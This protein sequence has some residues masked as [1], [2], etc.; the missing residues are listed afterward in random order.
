LD[1][2]PLRESIGH[3][4]SAS[5]EL[6]QEKQDA[7][8][9]F[10]KLLSKL[11]HRRPHNCARG[12]FKKVADWIKGV[13]GVAPAHPTRFGY[14]SDLKQHGSTDPQVTRDVSNTA[15]D[16]SRYDHY[17]RGSLAEGLPDDYSKLIK[18]A[19]RVR[20]ANKKLT[21]FER[22]FIDEQGIKDRSW[23]RHLGVAPGKWL[24]K[25]LF[26]AVGPSR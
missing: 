12:R 24:G 26:D 16:G 14:S 10:K 6:D 1:L 3:L 7:E 25:F 20:K 15:G 11:P 19:K 13:F 9:S 2:T 5:A 22:G 4:Q 18:A 17:F 8:E 23:Y 21:A